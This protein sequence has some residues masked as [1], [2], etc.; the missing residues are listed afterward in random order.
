MTEHDE[1]DD[2]PVLNLDPASTVTITGVSP[3]NELAMMVTFEP[4]ILVDEPVVLTVSVAHDE[5]AMTDV[6]RRAHRRD[7][8]THR[9]R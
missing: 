3:S 2:W 6:Q 4:A 9:H 1:P 7:A 8:S 5:S